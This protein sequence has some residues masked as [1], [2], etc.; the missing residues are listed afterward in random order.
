MGTDNRDPR[1]WESFAKKLA[2]K[3]VA[4][5][6]D[7]QDLEQEAFLSVLEE[8]PK[9][10]EEV[11]VSLRVFLGRGIK[12]RLATL[13]RKTLNLVQI[14]QYWM[15]CHKSGDKELN[16]KVVDKS[17]G[18]AVIRA[19]PS[20]YTAVRHVKVMASIGPSLD[21]E[22]EGHDGSNA[23]T[24]HEVVGDRAEQEWIPTLRQRVSALRAASLSEEHAAE[25]ETIIKM[26]QEGF[27]LDEIGARFGKKKAAVCMI[28]ARAK[29][30]AAKAA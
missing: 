13:Y 17:Q 16:V 5:G 22:L 1:E 29:K 19:N 30:R 12:N 6:L 4:P 14:E 9:Y 24:L 7:L 23:E 21:E 18:E 15:V 20:E 11:G 3:Y 2:S 25:L 26:K 28:L 8:L 27:T 10:K